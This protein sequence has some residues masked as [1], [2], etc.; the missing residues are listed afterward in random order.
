MHRPGQPDLSGRRGLGRG[1]FGPA[2]LGELVA[3]R[4]NGCPQIVAPDHQGTRRHWKRNVIGVARGTAL[5][6]ALDAL[7]EQDGGVLQIPHHCFRFL[8]GPLERIDHGQALALLDGTPFGLGGGGSL[9]ACLRMMQSGRLSLRDGTRA[10]SV[11]VLVRCGS[12]TPANPD[13]KTAG[14]ERS[15]FVREGTGSP[16]FRLAAAAPSPGG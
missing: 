15:V 2:V 9:N 12:K 13:Q 16:Y 7:I 5:Q 1:P 10:V 6:F 11:A 3:K 14:S 8:P 4:R